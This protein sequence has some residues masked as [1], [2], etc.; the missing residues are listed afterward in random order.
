MKDEGS[1][2][3]HFQFVD[4]YTSSRISTVLRGVDKYYPLNQQDDIISLSLSL[5]GQDDILLDIEDS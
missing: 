4:F 5:A 2:K 1:G 3:I